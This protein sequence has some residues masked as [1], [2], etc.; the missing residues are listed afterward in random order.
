MLF[1]LA[2]E[3]VTDQV[4]IENILCG[5]FQNPDLDQDISELQPPFDETDQ[6][7][8]DGGW[9]MLLKYLA[10]ARFREDVLNTEFVI[11]QIDS[12]IAHQIPV[13]YQDNEGN[14]LS[15]ESLMTNIRIRLIESIDSGELSFYEANATKIIFSIC[16]H[17]LEC[18]LVAHHAEQT[19]IHNCFEV[20]KTAINSND[21]RVAKKRKNYDILSQPFLDRKNIDAVAEKDPSFRAFIQSLETIQDQVSQQT[22]P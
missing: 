10:S 13:E 7:H 15:V 8:G 4:T 1:G 18:W 3:G 11:L 14:E 9:P 20:L 2:C 19:A 17:S 12:D 6:K 16:V 22:S 21:I 5:Y